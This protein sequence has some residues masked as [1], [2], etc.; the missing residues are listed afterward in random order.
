M[1]TLQQKIKK[2]MQETRSSNINGATYESFKAHMKAM[3][4]K[5]KQNE[6]S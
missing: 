2:L 5:N 6:L 1:K 4:L 3:K